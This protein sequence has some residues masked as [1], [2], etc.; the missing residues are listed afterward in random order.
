MKKNT[1]KKTKNLAKRLSKYSALTGAMLGVSNASGQ[2]IY[3]DVNPDFLGGSSVN[4]ML[5]LDNDGN[6][7]FAINGYFG[8]GSAYNVSIVAAVYGNSVLG[9]NPFYIYPFA[10]NSGD[11]I[12][13]GQANPAMSIDWFYNGSLNWESCYNGAGN[14]NWCGVTDKYLGLRFLITGNTHYGWARLDVSASGDSFTVKDY[15]YNTTP[16]Q[17]INAGQQELGVKQHQLSKI[18]IIAQDK[19]ITIKNLNTTANYVLYDST[20]KQV[21]NGS[22][23]NNT[24][25]NAQMLAS[26]FY[27]ITIED[28]ENKTTINK[29][30]VL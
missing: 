26:G 20:G 17:P 30:I 11:P 23:T 3:T 2:I 21:L 7:E 28:V 8:D 6:H 14:S 16:N 19:N 12:S 27:V 10:L 13:S 22:V 29:K 1:C 4:Y 18:A 15:A 25:I 24:V 5:D 9:S